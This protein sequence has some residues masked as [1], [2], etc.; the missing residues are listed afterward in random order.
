MGWLF[1]QNWAWLFRLRILWRFCSRFWGSGMLTRRLSV[2]VYSSQMNLQLGSADLCGGW[3]IHGSGW[4]CHYAGS[5]YVCRV[6]SDRWYSIAVVVYLSGGDSICQ[7][8]KTALPVLTVYNET[9]LPQLYNFKDSFLT[10]YEVLSIYSFIITFLAHLFPI[11][12][13]ELF[14]LHMP[15]LPVFPGAQEKA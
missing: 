14:L 5:R 15:L 4:C 6:R 10:L 3:Q 8:E 12:I 1:W 13:F 2:E 9:F 7:S 11:F